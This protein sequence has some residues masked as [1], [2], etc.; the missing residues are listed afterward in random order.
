MATK[1]THHK[2]LLLSDSQIDLG[3][4]VRSQMVELLN[5]HL[6]NSADLYGQTKHAHWN[7]KGLQ[8]MQLHELFDLLA[9]GVEGYIDVVAERITALGGVA[10]GTVRMAAAASLLPET[11][12]GS[13]SGTEYLQHLVALYSQQ[14]KVARSAVDVASEA[15]DMGTSDL[16]NDYVRDLDKW[17]W[18][19]EAHLQG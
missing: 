19:L 15:G 4:Q 9:E 8:F 10:Q 7:V 13:A 18:F 14:A 6:A 1:Q 5:Q 16:F 11:T 3:H 2:E 12:L 17:R